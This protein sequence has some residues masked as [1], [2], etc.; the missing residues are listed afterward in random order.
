M[1]PKNLAGFNAPCPAGENLWATPSTVPSPA[2]TGGPGPVP[3][4]RAVSTPR[5]PHPSLRRVIDGFSLVA[6]PGGKGPGARGHR[7]RTGVRADRSCHR[8]RVEGEMIKGGWPGHR[9]DPRRVGASLLHLA[10][11]PS[12]AS[13]VPTLRPPPPAELRRTGDLFTPGE[14]PRFARVV[15]DAEGRRPDG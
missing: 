13:D 10:G 7:F 3:P 9:R 14:T 5:R 1:I 4:P 15:T 6:R 2:G 11:C 8:S 12:F